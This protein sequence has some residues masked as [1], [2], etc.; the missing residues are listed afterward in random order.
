[1]GMDPEEREDRSSQDE[2]SLRLMKAYLIEHLKKAEERGALS[3]E[4]VPMSDE[5]R[6][7]LKALGYVRQP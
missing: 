3:P 2:A 7:R 4:T 6:D 1:M 5:I